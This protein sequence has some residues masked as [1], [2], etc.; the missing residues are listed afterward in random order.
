MHNANDENWHTV[1]AIETLEK[2]GE[3]FGGSDI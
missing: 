3:G 1:P 2:A